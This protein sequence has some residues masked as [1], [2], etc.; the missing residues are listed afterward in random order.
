MV[1]M[2][3]DDDA[4][5]QVYSGRIQRGSIAVVNAMVGHT[6]FSVQ[7]HSTINDSWLPTGGPAKKQLCLTGTLR[8]AT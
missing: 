3:A 6:S 5:C 4:K 1:M 7:S 8:T 2:D